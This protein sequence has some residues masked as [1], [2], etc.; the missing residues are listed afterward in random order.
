[1]NNREMENRIKNNIRE[2]IAISNVRKEIEMSE[3]KNKS[4]FYKIILPSCSAVI[5]CGL[6]LIGG[7]NQNFKW[8]EAKTNENIITQ[9]SKDYSQNTTIIVSKEEKSGNVAENI[10]KNDI[11]IENENTVNTNEDTIINSS[12]QSKKE[13]KSNK[14][15]DTKANEEI[16]NINLTIAKVLNEVD[17]DKI[18]YE[19]VI[20]SESTSFAYR[21]TIENLYKNAD[22]VIIGKY[23]SDIKTYVKGIS[24][25]TQTKFNVSQVI[26]NTTKLDIGKT[27]TF[28]R[29][30]GVM[31]LDNYMN[32]NSTIIDGKFTEIN[33]NDRKNY[34]VI[35]EFG[36]E[37]TL[38][39]TKINSNS[40]EYML[41]LDY[42]NGEFVTCMKYYGIR[43]INDNKIYDYDTNNYVETD[44]DVINKALK[45]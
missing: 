24:I 20:I 23:N 18:F 36:P 27:I 34:Y 9:Q 40:K 16:N 29:T 39:F 8:K 45:K 13:E 32:N 7:N 3:L 33:S 5:I 37:N 21:P 28:D 1:M 19:K 2:R 11:V 12:E 44:N 38:D 10:E 41:F 26:K 31:T 35:Q 22:A 6:L 30:G 42:A 14:K 43:E 17:K 4:R 15:E 25:C